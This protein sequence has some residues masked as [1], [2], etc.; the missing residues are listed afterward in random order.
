MLNFIEIDLNNEDIKFGLI[1]KATNKIN[2]KVYI[3]QTCSLLNK[4]IY[5]H[6]KRS[7]NSNISN[8]NKFY[9]AIKKYG[10]ENFEWE[11]LQKNIPQEKLDEWEIKYI[12]EYN[13]FLDGYNSTE[14]GK[15][16]S[17]MVFPETKAKI[18]KLFRLPIDVVLETLKEKN[19]ELLPNQDFI[20]CQQKLKFKCLLCFNEWQTKLNAIKH[21]NTKCPK[22][23]KIQ[24]GLSRR[25]KKS[26]V[27]K[28]LSNKNIV[29]LCEYT[30]SNDILPMQCLRCGDFFSKSVNFIKTH[31]IG[32]STCAKNKKYTIDDVKN[33]CTNNNLVLISE[34]Y[35]NA[36]T[37]MTFK[38]NANHIWDTTFD[39]I[40]RGTRCQKCYHSRLRK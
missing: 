5:D 19:I 28:S 34:S 20:N 32:C 27:D 40:L 25:L 29:L 6:K 39:S 33:F 21:A 31:K 37:K 8:N 4:R 38:C 18:S 22:C 36:R 17:P 3:G 11:I 35:I 9:N 10:F 1:Y 24:F 15:R 7:K 13:S 12:R 14:G 2:G 16:S 26:D 23:S 30:T